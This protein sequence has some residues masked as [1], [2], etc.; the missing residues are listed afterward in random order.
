MLRWSLLAAVAVQAPSAAPA[1]ATRT[2]SVAPFMTALVVAD[3]NASAAWYRDMLDFREVRRF[4]L[5]EHGLLIV[6]LERD[7]FRLE[8]VQNAKSFSVNRYV[9]DYAR[10]SALLQGFA[11][12][13]FK[14]NS[15]DSLAADLRGKG[16]KFVFPLGTDENM[17]QRHFIVEDRDGNLVQFIQPLDG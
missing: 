6:F 12:M 4:D 15:A 5:P 9:P 2:V 3:A 7:G 11:K 14:V 8:L 1:P 17:R 10:S 13:A 16:V